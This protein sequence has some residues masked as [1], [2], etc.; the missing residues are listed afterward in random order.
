MSGNQITISEQNGMRYLHFGTE[1][2]Q[3]GMRVARPYALEISYLRDMMAWLLF[4]DGPAHILQLGLG[5]GS[6]AKF[7]HRHC[8]KSTIEVAELDT[9]VID[10]ARQWFR[11]PPDDRRLQ[12]HCADAHT[13]L[14]NPHSR[15]RNGVIQIDLYDREARGPVLDSVGFYRHAR[16]ALAEVGVVCVNLFGEPQ[17]YSRN[18]AN[19]YTAFSGRLLSLPPVTEGN[20]VVLAFSGPELT[21]P[22]VLL[23]QRAQVI[24]DQLGLPARAWANLLLAGRSVLQV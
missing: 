5:A 15:G 7:C 4:L 2:V 17:S 19:L 6:L 23:R 1:W 11:L 12:V 24:E 21:V 10:A 9:A 3:G 18:Y 14:R 22:A 13:W 20:V 16:R 8:P